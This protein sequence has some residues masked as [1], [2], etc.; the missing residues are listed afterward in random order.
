MSEENGVPDLFGI[1]PDERWEWAPRDHREI[2]DP[3]KFVA[4]TESWEKPRIYGKPKEGATVFVLKPLL[5][6]HSIKL[7]NAS[8]RFELS[9]ARAALHAIN[10]AKDKDFDPSE[11]ENSIKVYDEKL[12]GE[13]VAASLDGW[14]N[15]KDRRGKLIPYTGTSADVK[16]IPG[17]I[18]AQIFWD[19][20][21][22]RLGEDIRDSFESGPVSPQA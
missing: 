4:E 20:V 18:I 22:D 7:A 5:E 12:I 13:I 3:G 2:V 8:A 10:H 14:K 16:R 19:I 17:K 9:S 6:K 11:I 1:D 15:F 21:N